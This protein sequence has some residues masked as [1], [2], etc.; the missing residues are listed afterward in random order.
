MQFLVSLANIT[1]HCKT[2]SIYKNQ[3]SD[4]NRLQQ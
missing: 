1:E 3:I 4:D 2:N